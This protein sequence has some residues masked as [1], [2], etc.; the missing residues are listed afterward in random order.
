MDSRKRPAPGAEPIGPPYHPL[1]PQPYMADDAVVDTL[2]RWNG[3]SD[4]V[5][6][7]DRSALIPSQPSQYS[8]QGG[9]TP[10]N[11]LARRPVNQMLVPMNSSVEPWASLADSMALPQPANRDGLV[12]TDNV[13]MLEEMAAKAKQESQNKRKQIPPFVQKI[14]S[15][16]EEQ[17]NEE[18][19]R[20]SEKGDSFVVLDEEEFAK[21]L[22]PELFKHNNYASFVRQL[23]MYG[24][25]KRVGL[26]DNSMRASER[27]NKS[28]SEYYNPYFR[29]GHPN[30]LWLINKPKNGSK[31]KAKKGGKSADGEADS[32]DDGPIDDSMPKG[33]AAASATATAT[34]GRSL[35][36]PDAHAHPQTP[37]MALIKDE[38][39]RVREQQN[40]I[41]EAIN[42]LQRNNHD[43]YNQAL[44]FQN[45]HDRHQNS[46]NAILNFLAN[47]FRKTL[48]D[49]NHQNVGEIIS[50]MMTNQ[51]SQPS[52]QQGSVFDLGDFVQS[53]VDS[54]TPLGGTHKRA[55]GLLPPIPQANEAAGRKGGTP[56]SAGGS[57]PFYPGSYQDAEMGHVTELLDAETPPS[58][59]QELETNP[60][61]RMMKIINDHNASN[62]SGV[63]LPEATKIVNNTPTTLNSDQTSK[64]VDLMSRQRSPRSSTTPAPASTTLSTSPAPKMSESV[65]SPS[66]PPPAADPAAALALSPTVRSPTMQPP[67]LNQINANQME[68][69][70][71]QQLQSQQDAKIHEIS[72]MLGPLSP[73]G[74][75]PGL[76]EGGDSYY[77]PPAV[78]LDPY[79]D[80]SAFL[81]EVDFGNGDDFNFAIDAADANN[82]GSKRAAKDVPSPTRTEEIHREELEGAP[83]PG[84]DDKRRRRD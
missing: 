52:H 62:T 83:S 23:N 37:Q 35:P 73:S 7:I 46:I 64:L 9:P 25:H 19:I 63:D 75:I 11:S 51:S 47:V 34:G 24:F 59:R 2:G 31:E 15:F 36:A 84:H 6:S 16:L 53:Q 5:E 28:P 39:N 29:R 69:S 4:G 70:Q 80:S 30:L 33:P 32:E 79:F 41:L 43:L 13:E 66:P 14:S 20:W 44:R 27:K 82:G 61:E 74:H 18:L 1:M 67:S 17:K 68:V 38:L 10:S 72:E 57:T 78:D 71:L 58:L 60:Q 49:G 45:Q 26:S 40:M 55:R 76:E 54:T 56:S 65:F 81:N 48:E 50:S 22:I 77:F 12:E 21:T 42:Q 8:I 3:P